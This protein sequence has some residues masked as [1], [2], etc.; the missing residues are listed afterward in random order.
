MLEMSMSDLLAF[1]VEEMA[2]FLA[3]ARVV[4]VGGEEFAG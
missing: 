2:S 4:H 3:R 1:V